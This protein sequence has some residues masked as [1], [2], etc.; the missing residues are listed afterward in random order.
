MVLVGNKCDLPSRTVDTKQAQDLARSYGIPFIETSAKTRQVKLK[1]YRYNCR[2]LMWILIML[3]IQGIGSCLVI[4]IDRFLQ[5][6]KSSSVSVNSP[7]TGNCLL[8][9]DLLQLRKLKRMRPGL[10]VLSTADNFSLLKV[11]IGFNKIKSTFT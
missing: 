1:T 7:T 10:L 4:S 11:A 9:S 3:V 5:S 6:R 2:T 8:M